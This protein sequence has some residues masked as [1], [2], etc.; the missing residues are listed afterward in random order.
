MPGSDFALS[1][2]GA[3]ARRGAADDDESRN[4][5]LIDQVA[6]KVTQNLTVTIADIVNTQLR[7]ALDSQRGA[8]RVNPSGDARRGAVPG[9]EDGQE[10]FSPP[11]GG[12]G[13]VDD[14]DDGASSA[15][16]GNSTA[17]GDNSSEADKLWRIVGERDP[18]YAYD[19]A[20]QHL[21][22]A[23]RKACLGKPGRTGL[24]KEDIP[25]INTLSA[26]ARAL[27]SAQVMLGDVSAE[28]EE[29]LRDI[30]SVSSTIDDAIACLHLQLNG[31]AVRECLSAT[32]AK[33]VD[34]AARAK[35]TGI[36]TGDG[37]IPITHTYFNEILLE[38]QQKQAKNHLKK[39]HGGSDSRKGKADDDDDEPGPKKDKR[40]DANSQTERKL[41]EA[42]KHIRK[43]EPDWKPAGAKV[44]PDK[45][46]PPAG[47][48]AAGAPAASGGSGN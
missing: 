24:S 37:G 17:P 44:A 43:S 5:Q 34:Q 31:L 12:G 36:Y 41:Q 9:A 42:I 33:V 45:K 8:S 28:S 27:L 30:E 6:T 35:A 47:A 13:G 32:D 3:N 40:K 1:A 11:L 25:Q 21:S 7:E 4:D 29:Q 46:K 14:I 19:P 20:K 10:D 48:K 39:L 2:D 15:L 18:A 16:S 22:V 23:W 26:S 38:V